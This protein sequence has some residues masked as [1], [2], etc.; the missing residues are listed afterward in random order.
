MAATKPTNG[1]NRLQ[2]QLFILNWKQA[3][4]NRGFDIGEKCRT[5]VRLEQA[6]VVDDHYRLT[7]V[8]RRVRSTPLEES[9]K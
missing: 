2:K 1:M 3:E 4:D 7:T 5:S 6:V 9:V 8:L